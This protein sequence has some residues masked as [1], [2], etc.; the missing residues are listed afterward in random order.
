MIFLLSLQLNHMNNN[1]KNSDSIPTRNSSAFISS[2]PRRY[3]LSKLIDFSLKTLFQ[4]G[5][6]QPIFIASTQSR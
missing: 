1:N 2:S 5:K 3:L 4:K 6:Q